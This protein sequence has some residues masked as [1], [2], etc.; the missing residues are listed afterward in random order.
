[1]HYLILLRHA[2]A[3]LLQGHQA[4]RDRRLTTAGQEEAQRIG[5]WLSTSLYQPQ[6]VL[7]SAAIRTRETWAIIAEAYETPP[8]VH[9][10]DSLY[11]API[12]ELKRQV[13]ETPEKYNTL[14]II[15]HN[16][17]LEEL[18]SSLVGPQGFQAMMRAGGFP[19]AAAAVL[20]LED[21]WVDFPGTTVHLQAF[22]TP[23]QLG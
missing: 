14:L 18:A 3:E 4:D 23:A 20:R 9:F 21:G 10:V 15:G 12:R 8:P 19:T 16:P 6:L 5:S 2:K 7:C 17:G 22:M 1:M 13:R 11:E